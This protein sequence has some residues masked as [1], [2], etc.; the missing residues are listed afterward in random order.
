MRFNLVV[1]LIVAFGGPLY[2]YLFYRVM[3]PRVAS[4]EGQEGRRV[5]IRNRVIVIM[6]ACE[7]IALGCVLIDPPWLVPAL[8]EADTVLT[9][10]GA[11]LTG[12]GFLSIFAIFV[13]LAYL[14][15]HD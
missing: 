5:A 4:G 15:K 12:V 14:G 1:A 9:I 6:I 2:V 11:A 7:I 13:S 8:S 10:L 3:L